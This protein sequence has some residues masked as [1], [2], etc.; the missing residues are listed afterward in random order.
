MR[1][2][3]SRSL[4]VVVLISVLVTPVVVGEPQRAPATSEPESLASEIGF[5]EAVWDLIEDLLTTDQDSI[6]PAPESESDPDLGP[7]IDPGG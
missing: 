5:W 3:F 4:I 7:H 1:R 6:T 2:V